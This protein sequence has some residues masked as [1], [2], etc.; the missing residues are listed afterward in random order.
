MRTI[1]GISALAAAACVLLAAPSARAQAGE[2]AAPAEAGGSVLLYDQSA[3][4]EAGAVRSQVFTDLGNRALEAADDFVVPGPLSWSV[5]TVFLDGRFNPGGSGP[6]DAVVLTIYDAGTSPGSP[7]CAYP[8]LAPTPSATDPV[9]ELTLPAPCGLGPGTYW[10][11]AQPVMAYATSQWFWF[12]SQTQA[13][14]SYEWRDP[15]DLVPGPA[16]GEWTDHVTC[17]VGTAAHDL[18]F[19]LVGR[20]LSGLLIF[21]DDFEAGN[22][23][24]WSSTVP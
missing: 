24:A 23:G 2:A 4:C 8:A 1:S 20:E 15:D 18:C 5:E 10:I 21:A 17:G 13:G 22:T 12:E 19:A 7:V 11:S 3:G 9:F 6:V 16:C 14:D